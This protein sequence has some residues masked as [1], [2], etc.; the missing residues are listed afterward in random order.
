MAITIGTSIIFGIAPFA[1]SKITDLVASGNL[2][3]GI[4]SN[5][6]FLWASIYLVCLAVGRFSS[7]LSLYFQSMLRLDVVNVLSKI[8][9][10]YIIGQKADFF[11]IKNS[12]DLSQELN[13]ANNDFY[14]IIRSFSGSVV[15]PIIQ[16]ASSFL[17][18]LYTEN[19]PVVVYFIIY[20]L[21]FS[22]NNAYFTKKL[23]DKKIK[24]MDAG[25]QSHSVL[26]DSIANISVAK[27]YGSFDFFFARY[28]GVLD[29]DRATQSE[30]W[31]TTILMLLLNTTL[32]TTLYVVSFLQVVYGVIAGSVTIGEFVMVASYIVILTS[33]IENLGSMFTEVNQSVMTFGA[34]L[35][36]I[37][38]QVTRAPKAISPI[39]SNNKIA[40]KVTQL[41]FSYMQSSHNA[42]EDVSFEIRSGNSIIWTGESGSGKSTLVK[43]LTGQYEPSSGQ[44]Q[45]FGVNLEDID[46]A[47][48]NGTVGVV[49]QDVMIFKDTL[50]FNLLMAKPDADDNQLVEALINA[51]LGEFFDQ[52]PEKLDTLLGDR[53]TKLS[54]GQRQRISFAR[55]FL[56]SPSIVIVDEGTSSLDV[57]T[58]RKVLEKLADYF[59]TRTVITIS[60]RASAMVNSDAIFVFNRG[61][62]QDRGTRSELKGRNP[63]FAQL[64]EL[65]L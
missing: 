9:F 13:Q 16:I 65:S 49:S 24:L 58:E 64:L 19:Y 2:A 61:R 20:I 5:T 21:A 52:L 44:I 56:T 32:F 63:Y 22:I 35:S 28:T 36:R 47:T 46:P 17:V 55:L 12:G 51:G 57:V 40:L 50:R 38:D 6:I 8:Y 43:I 59:K 14:V 29:Q 33:P 23:Y 11:T 30:Y 25:R 54:G 26:V 10:R 37:R 7:T 39:F 45:V 4:S 3:A 15:S 1:L 31:R 60:H 62:L 48:L 42:L 41:S 34:F 27:Q 18:L 53:G